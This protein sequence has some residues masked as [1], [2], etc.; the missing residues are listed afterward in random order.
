MVHK[1]PKQRERDRVRAA[2]HQASC[3][4]PTTA[5]PAVLLPF[6]GKLLP[7]NGTSP[8]PAVDTPAASP[9][10]NKDAVPA[11]TPTPPASHPP[12][13]A[14]PK[15]DI[16]STKVANTVKLFSKDLS[17]PHKQL[18]P[19]PGQSGKGRCHKYV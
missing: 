13:A 15:K 2:K 1:G 7:M 12:A 4:S 18:P 11:A 9:S 6:H 19:D 14:G 5:A 8:P 16:P 10:S 3:K 17:A